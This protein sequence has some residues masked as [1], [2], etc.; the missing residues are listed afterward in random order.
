LLNK[1]GILLA[2]S[3]TPEA[4]PADGREKWSWFERSAGTGQIVIEKTRASGELTGAGGIRMTIPI[5]GGDAPIG[6]LYA[7]I[8]PLALAYQAQT[9]TDLHV[10][11]FPQGSGGIIIPT[12]DPASGDSYPDT[13]FYLLAPRIARE[14]SGTAYYR[15]TTLKREYNQ[16]YAFT[17]LDTLE[18]DENRV[19]NLG[20]VIVAQRTGDNIRDT[21][22]ATNSALSLVV[23]TGAGLILLSI[24][25]VV[26]LSY[27]P[28]LNLAHVAEHILEHDDFEHPIP[29]YSGSEAKILTGTIRRLAERLHHQ[30]THLNVAVK[31]SQESLLL[32]LQSILD[33]SVQMMCEQM[34]YGWVGIYGS[35]SGR[36]RASVLAATGTR[37]SEEL[38]KAGDVVI[39]GGHTL[40]GRALSSQTEQRDP[41]VDTATF[42]GAKAKPDQVVIPLAGKIPGA[43]HVIANRANVF[44]EG[45]LD[46]L[47]LIANQIG[48]ILE[49]RYLLTETEMAKEDA[50]KA[51]H[52]K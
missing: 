18:V 29:T 48:F 33:R 25:T 9:D 1:D 44:T 5:R 36:L 32:D 2:V 7:V 39:A 17:A 40:A 3:P 35:E 30:N 51:S 23:W 31:V 24:L 13:L 27:R 21:V 14:P 11:V 52:V 4:L 8:D 15:S 26:F 19:I 46:I 6:V 41:G 47:R 22:S 49:N 10:N 45:D 38:L 42:A 28:I 20:W 34:D 50:E 16:V 12:V 43:L 37:T